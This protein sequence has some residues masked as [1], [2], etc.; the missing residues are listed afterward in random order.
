MPGRT[1]RATNARAATLS[2]YFESSAGESLA[3][4]ASV[5]AKTVYVLLSEI[6]NQK[7][8]EHGYLIIKIFESHQ[9][10]F[11]PVKVNVF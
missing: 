10:V 7:I 5:G 4:A 3:K 11:P 2:E 1:C 9:S 6:K 8:V